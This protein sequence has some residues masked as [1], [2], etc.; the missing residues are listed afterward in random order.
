MNYAKP[1]IV[2][3]TLLAS[4]A[5]F[6]AVIPEGSYPEAVTVSAADQ[7]ANVQAARVDTVGVRPWLG[8]GRP[9]FRP[10]S[11]PEASRADVI[12]ARDDWKASGL[13]GLSQAAEPTFATPDYQRRLDQ[14]GQGDRNGSAE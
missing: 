6:S 12:H 8:E 13:A 10:Y 9:D 11:G 1:L 3:A 7:R 14:H 2:A 5:A 4:S